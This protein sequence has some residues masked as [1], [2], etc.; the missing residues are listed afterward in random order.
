MTVIKTASNGV[1]IHL[2]LHTRKG[3][4]FISIRHA[5]K[6]YTIGSLFS[7]GNRE[8]AIKEAEYYAAQRMGFLPQTR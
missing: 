7:Y 5:I 2:Y 1:P 4:F 6:Q 3:G 8:E